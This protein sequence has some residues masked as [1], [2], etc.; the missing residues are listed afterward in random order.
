MKTPETKSPFRSPPIHSIDLFASH[1]NSNL[2]YSFLTIMSFGVIGVFISTTIISFG[3]WWLFPKL[4]FKGLIARDYLA[5]R[6][7]LSSTDTVCTLQVLDF[8]KEYLCPEIPSSQAYETPLLYS[9][10]LGEGV[11][12]DAT[13]V[14][15]FNYLKTFCTSS[16]QAQSSLF[17]TQGRRQI[18]LSF[19]VVTA[20]QKDEGWCYIGCF[21]WSKKLVREGSFFTCVACNKTNVVTELRYRAILSVLDNTGTAAFLGFDTKVTKLTGI[22]ASEAA[23]IVVDTDLPRSLA[24]IVGSTYTFQLRLKDFNFTANHQTFTI[25]LIFPARELA[26]MPTFA[27]GVQVPE[28]VTPGSDARLANTCKVAEQATTSDVSLP[29]RLAAAKGQVVLERMPRRKHV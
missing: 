6:T 17:K 15:H 5:I 27:E 12:N 3:T 25:S 24:D 11:V 21:G 8:L 20:I 14:F 18:S 9:L 19:S 23:Q 16:P 7:I 29:G 10:V 22:E 13:S 26:P 1:S 2:F 4:G 28:A